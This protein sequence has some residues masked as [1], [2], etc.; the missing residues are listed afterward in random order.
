[1]HGQNG[2]DLQ[3][4]AKRT[5][6]DLLDR[7]RAFGDERAMIVT[8]SPDRTVTYGEFLERVAHT[9]TTFAGRLAK[10]TRVACL[11][12]NSLEH[13]ILRYALSCAGLV[14][15]AVNGAHRGEVLRHML[16]LS[17]PDAVVVG[18]EFRGN[19]ESCG[20][21]LHGRWIC[22]EAELGD[23][24]ASRRRWETR[25]AVAIDPG[26]CCRILF[27]SGT[28]GRS[29]AVELSHAY[30]VF[31]G[32]RH[33]GLIPIGRGDRMLFVTPLFHIDAVYIVSLLLHTGATLALAP[34]FS[35]SRFWDDVR[36]TAASHL[37]YVGSIIAI[38]LKGEGP[39]NT[40]TLRI[41]TGGGA[42]PDDAREF[43]TRFGVEILESYA[44]TE[45]IAC[46]FN[47][48]A[49]RRPGSIGRAVPG[50]EVAIHGPGG[51]AAPT[52]EAGEI[53]VRSGEPFG[54][55]T[56]Y[57]GDPDATLAAMRGG[58]FHTG[59]LGSMDADGYFTYRGRLKDSIR[60][61]GE[62]V[63]ALELE[64]I[65]DSHPEIQASAA[66]AVPSEIGDDDILLYV[67]P[68]PGAIV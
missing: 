35:L 34:G 36:R 22:G 33:M 57:V 63:S 64:A 38:L 67:E 14:E 40:H 53:V 5:V 48:R 45:C 39:L 59:D 27:T 51:E 32:Q 37:S 58:W 24:V 23:I 3:T 47:P 7:S 68:K 60:V 19:L 16:E 9:A 52:G 43:E 13:L 55:F 17:Q 4:L 65:V 30:E 18:D 12:G 15:I 41:G 42:R 49:E 20:V 61:R 1:M 54:L 50:Y 56:R 46:T 8:V 6:P 21:D 31:T 11:L 26:D 2:L 25:P 10:G 66:V 29:K 44:M 28:G 62:N